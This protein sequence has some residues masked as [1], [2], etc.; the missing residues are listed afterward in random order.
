MPST[1]DKTRVLI[2]SIGYARLFKRPLEVLEA[3]GAD[4]TLHVTERNLSEDEI[5][6]LI[7]DY[8]AHIAGLEPLTPRVLDNA[9]KLGLI[10][11]VGCEVEEDDDTE[12]APWPPCDVEE[13]TSVLMDY[14]I[15]DW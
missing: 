15:Y 5:F 7:G 4:V 9:P 12:W 8:D 13:H 6:G 10:A 3:A 14:C 11:R 2:T 1:N